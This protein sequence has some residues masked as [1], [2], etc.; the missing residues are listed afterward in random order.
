M[1]MKRIATKYVGLLLTF[2]ASAAT[3]IGFHVAGHGAGHE[4]WHNWAVAH[5]LSSLGWLISGMIHIKRH[6]AWYR[7]IASKGIGHKSRTTI[8]L[9]A[10][11]LFVTVTGL[12]LII[13]VDGA[14]SALG[15]WHY[16]SGLILILLSLIHIIS[17]KRTLQKNLNL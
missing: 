12:I 7:A 14:N 3:G 6:W 16:I 10:L 17:R 15:R 1:T 5:V 8:L 11:F 9:S 4:E 13:G 2:V